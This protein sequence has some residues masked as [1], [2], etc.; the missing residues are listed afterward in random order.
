MLDLVVVL[1]VVRVTRGTVVTAADFPG[2]CSFVIP[3]QVIAIAI[4]KVDHLVDVVFRLVMEHRAAGTRA[5]AVRVPVV[6]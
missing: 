3:D 1:D 4:T 6:V 5:A 2:A